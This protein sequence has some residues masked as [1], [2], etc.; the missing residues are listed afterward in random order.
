MF[1]AGHVLIDGMGRLVSIDRGFCAI[2]QAEPAMLIGRAVMNV[3]APAD[4]AECGV[5]IAHLRA[6][7]TPFR[8]SKRFI[9]DNGSLVW[10]VNSVSMVEGGDGPGMIV[11]TID[12]IVDSSEPRAPAR[13]LDCAQLLVTCREDR[14]AVLDPALITDTAWDVIL[15]AYIAEAEGRS[16][17][18]ASLA[19]A[20]DLPAARAGRWID[21]LQ[22]KGI[23]EIETRAAD[24]H[25]AKAFRLTGDAHR[26]LE[27]HLA[28]VTDLQSGRPRLST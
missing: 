8:I 17:S 21:I 10:V 1:Q 5:A 27:T 6:T 28:K 3:T 24:A 2:M 23:I 25:S 12:P 26:R 18:V 20:L 16:I 7:H 4:R 15:A 9:R 19:A 13:L 11:A 14:A 22:G